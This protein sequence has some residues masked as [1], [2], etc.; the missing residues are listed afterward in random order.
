MDTIRKIRMEYFRVV[1][2]RRGQSDSDP[3]VLFDL[4]KWI[5]K[6]ERLSLEART[7]DYQAEQ[8]RLD[9]L[10]YNS[11][12]E[13]WFLNFIKL[14]ET[15]IP[16]KAKIDSIAEPMALADDEYIGEDVNALYDDELYILMLQ[17]NRYSLGVSGIEEYL[18]L[19]WDGQEELRLYL[20]PIA[21]ANIK[22]KI[23]GKSTYRKMTVRFNDIQT[24]KLKDTK[25]KTFKELFDSI[26]KYQCVAAEIN[27]TMSY[28]K[29]EYLDAQTVKDTI[30]D[31]YNNKEIISKAEIS[32]K[33]DIDDKVEVLDL[34]SDKWHD[35]IFVALRKR[36][37]LASE[38]V[39]DS[40]IE[41]YNET[42]PI[43]AK[44]L[45]GDN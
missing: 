24:K 29:T 3:D 42:R 8:A 30:D 37:S 17:R 19:I 45:E 16:H 28:N 36:E 23:R 18:N 15:N 10:W 25:S 33:D 13:Y 11:E 44:A 39:A 12:E 43:L 4:N 7:F 21:P 40:M 22:D 31:I 35:F 2:R 26:G 32:Y 14:R 20:R 27:I 41:T 34:F 1:C 6:A 5:E 9:R 38:Y